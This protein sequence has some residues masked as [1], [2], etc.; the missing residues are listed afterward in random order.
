MLCLTLCCL[1]FGAALAKP[2]EKA[3]GDDHAVASEEETLHSVRTAIKVDSKALSDDPQPLPK[4]TDNSTDLRVY[5]HV[6]SP[7]QYY[8]TSPNYPNNY[9]SGIYPYFIVGSSGQTIK[10][11]CNLFNI[12]CDGASFK[13]NGV[14]Y[15][16]SSSVNF[17]STHLAILFSVTHINGSL[18]YCLIKVP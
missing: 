10:I 8:F 5:Y 17:S 9:H 18:F 3:V 13:I 11:A 4:P 15:C 12:P 14:E 6:I 2:A 7:G 1:V 16:G